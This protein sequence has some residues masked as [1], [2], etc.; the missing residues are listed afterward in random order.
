MGLAGQTVEW[1]R[2]EDASSE[3]VMS[4]DP[5]A[6]SPLRPKIFRRYLHSLPS[7]LVLNLIYSPA[8]HTMFCPTARLLGGLLW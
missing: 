3:V 4:F 6:K 2:A 1:R 7:T 5:C 8:S